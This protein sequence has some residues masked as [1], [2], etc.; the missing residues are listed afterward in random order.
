MPFHFQM[1]VGLDE[2]TIDLSFLVEFWF[3]G[4]GPA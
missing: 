4:F 2:S 1:W 3:S